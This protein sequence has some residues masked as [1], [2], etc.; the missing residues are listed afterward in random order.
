MKSAKIREK[1]L[2]IYFS[3]SSD[4]DKTDCCPV[5]T[6]KF[7]FMFIIK[8]TIEEDWKSFLLSVTE[9][10]ELFVIQVT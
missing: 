7:I 2:Y 1:Y 3:P 9:R 4:A 6:Y 8:S 10:S 5:S